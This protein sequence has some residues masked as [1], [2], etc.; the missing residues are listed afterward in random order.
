[1]AK[2]SR[3]VVPRGRGGL[4]FPG[5]GGGSGMDGEFAVLYLEWMG[6]GA[7]LYSTGNCVWLGYF[8][9][10]QKL[11]KYCKSTIMLKKKNQF[12]K[13]LAASNLKCS[14][15]LIKVSAW[16]LWLSRLRI[17]IVTVAWVLSLAREFLHSLTQPKNKK[18]PKFQH[19]YWKSL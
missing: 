18:S 7:L 12:D 8:A 4:L 5:E 1:M 2:E 13:P 17:S 16:P 6:G 14:N 11:K 3:L 19:K 10:Q 9:V 15:F